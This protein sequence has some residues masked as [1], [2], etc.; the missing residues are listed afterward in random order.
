MKQSIR[1]LILKV[2]L[3]S[4]GLCSAQSTTYVHTAPGD[5]GFSQSSVWPSPTMQWGPKFT[6]TSPILQ[7]GSYRIVLNFQEIPGGAVTGP[8]QRVFTVAWNGSTSQPIDLWKMS[9]TSPVTFVGLLTQTFPGPVVI[10]FAASV[11]NAVVSSIDITTLTPPLIQ[12]M[13][14]ISSAAD[15]VKQPCPVAYQGPRLDDGS[16]IAVFFSQQ[17]PGVS[18]PAQN[19]SGQPLDLVVELKRTQ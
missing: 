10:T 3:F 8:N 16:C 11:R 4:I 17:A 18:T 9:G 13:V 5:A 7:P 15:V 2:F 1:S 19:T 14:F 12:G 6:Y